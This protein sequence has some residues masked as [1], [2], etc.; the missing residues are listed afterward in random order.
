MDPLPQ[1][2]PVSGRALGHRRGG[3]GDAVLGLAI[4]A[5]EHLIAGFYYQ[6]LGRPRGASL[7]ADQATGAGAL[8]IPGDL[9]GLPFLAAQL[10]QMIREDEQE[11]AQ[12]DAELDASAAAASADGQETA[13]LATAAQSHPWWEHDDR[14]TGRFRGVDPGERPPGGP[15]Q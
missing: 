12:V 6:G 4:I 2:L 5:D 13:G 8:W 10:I 14:F 1:R 15:A 11:A 7:R 3:G 9:V